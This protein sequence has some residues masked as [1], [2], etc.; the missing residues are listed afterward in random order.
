AA[1]PSSPAVAVAVPV[2]AGVIGASAAGQGTGVTGEAP[3]PSQYRNE[4]KTQPREQG[5]AERPRLADFGCKAG[6]ASYGYWLAGW[7]P[8]GIDKDPQPNYPFEFHQG[9]MLTYPL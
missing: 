6:G 9:D 3:K 2:P 7:Q 8:V 4:A 1:S 5:M